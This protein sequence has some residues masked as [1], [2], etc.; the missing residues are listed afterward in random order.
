MSLC[1]QWYHHNCCDWCRSGVSDGGANA[2]KEK[3]KYTDK[4]VAEGATVGGSSWTAEWR[5]FDNS[6]F[7]VLKEQ[8]DEDLLV[9]EPDGV[10]MTD[11]KFR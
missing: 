9:L 5:K 7:K 2:G 3:T 1:M 10:L 6:Y 8:D 11:P 4:A